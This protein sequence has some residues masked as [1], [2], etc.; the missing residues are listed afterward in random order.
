MEVEIV[1]T[2]EVS[3]QE[4]LADLL[5]LLELQLPYMTD[6]VIVTSKEKP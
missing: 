6:N 2:A 1:I 4:V 3:D 5:S